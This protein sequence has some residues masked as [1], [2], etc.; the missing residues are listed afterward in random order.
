MNYR[1]KTLELSW[2]WVSVDQAGTAHMKRIELTTRS[3]LHSLS[4]VAWRCMALALGFISIVGGGGG[5]CSV[6][7]V[8]V[9]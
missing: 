1:P 3:K 2:K 8:G 9:Y 5:A 6:C 7:S 4:G